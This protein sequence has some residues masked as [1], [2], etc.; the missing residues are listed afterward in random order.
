MNP[1]MPQMKVL[2]LISWNDLGHCQYTTFSGD[3]SDNVLGIYLE[4]QKFFL[5]QFYKTKF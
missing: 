2:E 3:V 5:K 1:F 4:T